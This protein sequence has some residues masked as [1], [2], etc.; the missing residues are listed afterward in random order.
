M[1]GVGWLLGGGWPAFI[2]Y[3]TFIILAQFWVFRT[4][5]TNKG[6]FLFSNIPHIFYLLMTLFFAL[7]D[8]VKERDFRFDL[9]IDAISTSFLI[10]AF[11]LALLVLQFILLKHFRSPNA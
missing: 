5:Y 2:L 9:L 7:Y 1:L 4:A 3:S 11:S 6:T 8:Q 10:T